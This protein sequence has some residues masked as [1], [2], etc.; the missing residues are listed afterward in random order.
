MRHEPQH[1]VMP[2]P[3]PDSRAFWDACDEGR[4]LLLRCT[5]CQHPSYYPRLACPRCS[6]RELQWLEA[7]GRGVVYSHT[8]VFTSFYGADW[9]PDIP[10]A[11]LLVD[12]EEGPRMLTRLVGDDEGL[13]TGSRVQVEFRAIN[14]RS[15]PF[16]AL[17]SGPADG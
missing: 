15:Y 7:S 4:L 17:E 5:N 6:G 10:Y 12:L 11:V 9:E 8:T 13:A 14:G 3:T 1:A 2:T 16:F